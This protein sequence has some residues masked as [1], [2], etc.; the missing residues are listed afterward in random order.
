LATI[1]REVLHISLHEAIS[2]KKIAKVEMVAG[3]SLCSIPYN[4]TGRL[5]A[6]NTS[7]LIEFI[8]E[9]L[10]EQWIKE[11]KEGTVAINASTDNNGSCLELPS[12]PATQPTN[13]A[14]RRSRI[15][16]ASVERA[17]K[18]F[19]RKSSPRTPTME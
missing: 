18:P 13:S 12:T 7:P 19:V 2:R 4:A 17:P 9:L 3:T 16:L 11:V 6:M 10:V 5:F 15:K 8:A 14:N 1:I